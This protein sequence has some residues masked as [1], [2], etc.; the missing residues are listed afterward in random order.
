MNGWTRLT[1]LNRAAADLWRLVA[2][3]ASLAAASPCIGGEPPATAPSD[4]AEPRAPAVLPV[5]GTLLLAPRASLLLPPADAAAV[6]G[7]PP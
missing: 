3:C 6:L 2:A 1:P 5:R 4:L 7:A